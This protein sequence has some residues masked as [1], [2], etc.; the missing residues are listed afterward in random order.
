MVFKINTLILSQSKSTV[1]EKLEIKN[2][3]NQVKRKIQDAYPTLTEEDLKY[4]DGQEEEL[5]E[6]LEDETGKEREE[7]IRWINQLSRVSM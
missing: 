1:M 3:W 5:L 7:L 6:R 4:E 2:S